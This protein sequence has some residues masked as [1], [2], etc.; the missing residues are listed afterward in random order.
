MR[1]IS[2]DGIIFKTKKDYYMYLYPNLSYGRSYN[3]FIVYVSRLLDQDKKKRVNEQARK[4]NHYR[5][6][7]DQNY[8]QLQIQR[9]L[10]RQLISQEIKRLNRIDVN[11]FN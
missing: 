4:I 8:K 7:T 9:M 1:Y 5:Y 6:N 11:I 2:N 10:K 3:A